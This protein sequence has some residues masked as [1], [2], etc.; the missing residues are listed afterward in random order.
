MPRNYAIQRFGVLQF[1]IYRLT[2]STIPRLRHEAIYLFTYFE[3]TNHSTATIEETTL[4]ALHEST[5]SKCR[6]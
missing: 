6:D 4:P 3:L 1:A 5:N 2:P